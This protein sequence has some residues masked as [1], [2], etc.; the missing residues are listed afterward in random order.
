MT[1][2]YPFFFGLRTTA[3]TARALAPPTCAITVDVKD[4]EPAPVVRIAFTRVSATDPYKSP[5]RIFSCAACRLFSASDAASCAVSPSV[6]HVCDP[7]RKRTLSSGWLAGEGPRSR[8]EVSGFSVAEESVFFFSSSSPA[9]AFCFA[10]ASSRSAC[11][12]R[13]PPPE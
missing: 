8:C 12:L 4:V 6:F 3:S 9:A 10:A 5:A 7:G 11:A 13:P 2:A 1:R